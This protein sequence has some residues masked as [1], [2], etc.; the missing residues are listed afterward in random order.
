MKHLKSYKIFESKYS[1]KEIEDILDMEYDSEDVEYTIEQ[2]T[3]FSEDKDGVTF[4]IKQNFPESSEISKLLKRLDNVGYNASLRKRLRL[5]IKL[6]AQKF[7][8][9]IFNR[10]EKKYNLESVITS[11]YI[12]SE[13]GEGTTYQ[14]VTY[15]YIHKGKDLDKFLLDNINKKTKPT[16]ESKKFTVY[17][18]DELIDLLEVE[19]DSYDFTSSV[20]RYGEEKSTMINITVNFPDSEIEKL[21]HEYLENR[22]CG[23]N[24]ICAGILDKLKDRLESINQPII[25]KFNLKYNTRLEIKNLGILAIY[26]PELYIIVADNSLWS[27]NHMHDG[28]D[29]KYESKNEYKLAELVDLL[30]VEYESEDIDISTNIDID[31][32]LGDVVAYAHYIQKCI[33]K[34]G[35]V[36]ISVNLKYTNDSEIGILY[37]K[38]EKQE[39]DRKI[40]ALNKREYKMYGYMI[41]GITIPVV[42]RRNNQKIVDRFN[43]KYNT[44]VE[45]DCVV[46]R[47][48]LG[49]IY[50]L[51]RSNL[52]RN[53][54][55]GEKY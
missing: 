10:I 55:T 54:A 48:N 9:L 26:L 23:F 16:N 46:F 13:I 27:N 42:I 31:D 44:D 6:K 36:D 47:P 2:S 19:Y 15:V 50:L 32:E 21:R 33:L 53:Y 14:I 4:S 40:D 3:M 22:E 12:N 5:D 45:I 1:S 25:D 20:E 28:W 38:W 11:C 35:L 17:N 30:E 34:V 43:K 18:T 24:I 49:G 37:E 7:N 41:E 51:L 52:N 29:K 39:S 8:Q